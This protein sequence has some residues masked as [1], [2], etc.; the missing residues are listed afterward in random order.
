M[1]RLIISEKELNKLK[2]LSLDKKIFNT[3]AIL[4]ETKIRQEKYLIKKLFLN[5]RENVA[6]KLYNISMLNKYKDYIN[7]K[8]FVIPEHLVVLNNCISN[9]LNNVKNDDELEK[10]LQDSNIPIKIKINMLKQVVDNVIGFSIPYIENSINLGL[11]LKDENIDKKEKIK[12][13]KK[14]GN[15]VKRI[16]QVNKQNISIHINDLHSFNFL[17]DNNTKEIKIVD[18]DS[19]TF[20]EDKAL[21]SNYMCINKNLKFIDKYKFDNGKSYPSTNNDLLCYNMMILDLISNS[22]VSKMEINEF[23]EYIEYLRSIGFGNNLLKSFS[24]LYTNANNI[25]PVDYLDEIPINLIGKASV[26]EFKYV[27]H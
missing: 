5:D 18:L 11:I 6:N 1:E 3:E 25:N 12:Y 4:Y 16:E 2:Q 15:I 7:I 21:S 26:E 8:E 13:L 19:S 17:V 23:Y 22:N 10:N 27:K 14:I 24:L 9:Q 20:M